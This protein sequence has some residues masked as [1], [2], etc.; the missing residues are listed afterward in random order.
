[1][2]LP[3]CSG[4]QLTQMAR[5]ASPLCARAAFAPGNGDVGETCARV[6]GSTRR[7][8]T[9]MRAMLWSPRL[10]GCSYMLGCTRLHVLGIA[11]D[12]CMIVHM[13]KNH[14]TPIRRLW[15]TRPIKRRN[16]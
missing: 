4:C 9:R 1:V 2:A 3:A 8:T 6:R 12:G 11:F 14:G 10:V 13:P 15:C 7:T 5:A 16:V